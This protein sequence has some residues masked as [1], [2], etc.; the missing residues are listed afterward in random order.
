MSRITNVLIGMEEEE[1]NRTVEELLKDGSFYTVRQ[2]ITAFRELEMDYG[3]IERCWDEIEPHVKRDLAELCLEYRG[4]VPL[5]IIDLLVADPDDELLATY[6][7]K[8]C[9]KLAN[10]GQEIPLGIISRGLLSQDGDVRC[11]AEYALLRI[12]GMEMKDRLN[13]PS[14]Q[15]HN[16]LPEF[17]DNFRDQNFNWDVIKGRPFNQT[18][19]R[20]LA[21]NLYHGYGEIPLDIF[22]A[23]L[24]NEDSRIREYAEALTRYMSTKVADVDPAFRA[25]ASFVVNSRTH[26]GTVVGRIPQGAVVIRGYGCNNY[27]SEA[28]IL[29]VVNVIDISIGMDR[30]GHM[31]I[32]GDKISATSF[33]IERDWFKFDLGD[34]EEEK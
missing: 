12:P 28:E 16:S 31:L 25:T 11:S 33:D 14:R 24:Q 4:D 18:S 10:E 8:I 27:A 1:R 7:M 13:M 17:L 20:L 6:G 5:S 3:I 30:S 23:G 34:E 26:T 19:V 32:R 9:E 22:Q 15:G 2:G 21:R 29:E